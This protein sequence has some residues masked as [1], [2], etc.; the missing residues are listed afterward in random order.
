V[1]AWIASDTHTIQPSDCPKWHCVLWCYVNSCLLSDQ[2]S[3]QMLQQTGCQY[4]HY[5]YYLFYFGLDSKTC[6]A[7]LTLTFHIENFLKHVYMYINATVW[8]GENFR[9]VILIDLL[10]QLLIFDRL[11]SFHVS[12]KLIILNAQNKLFNYQN[13]SMPKKYKQFIHRHIFLEKLDWHADNRHNKTFSYW[14][15]QTCKPIWQMRIKTCH[16]AMFLLTYWRLKKMVN[17]SL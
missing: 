17:I 10:W 1:H 16:L 6:N 11:F 9:V 7:S 14:H 13:K 15:M 2:K 12:N 4:G 5:V 8:L 3:F